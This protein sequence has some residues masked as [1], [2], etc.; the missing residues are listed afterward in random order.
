MR[1]QAERKCTRRHG[2]GLSAVMLLGMTPGTGTAQSSSGAI[3]EEFDLQAAPQ[4]VY[5][6]LLDDK[7]FASFSGAR[8]QIHREAGGTFE[9][10]GG[11][12]VGRN[13][14]LIPN[15]RIVQAWRPAS[16][17]AGVYSIVRFELRADGSGTHVT[18]DHTGF[19]PDLREH[20][21]SGW[22]ANYIGPL[23]KFL[24]KEN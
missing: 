4:R 23:K 5:E 6:A 13:V 9:M 16:W 17:P 10:F 14:E 7:Q 15:Q 20:L 18:L 8:A 11:L 22:Q 3:H 2:I 1:E 24:S 21:Q 19:P 12:I